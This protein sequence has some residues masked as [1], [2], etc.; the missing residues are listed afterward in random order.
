MKRCTI[1]PLVSGIFDVKG[2]E[3]CFRLFVSLHLMIANANGTHFVRGE[4]EEE[5]YGD[6][7]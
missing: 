3:L 6:E 1:K 7:F 5:G 4:G 2:G